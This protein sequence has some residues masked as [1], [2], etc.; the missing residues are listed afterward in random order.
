MR[1]WALAQPT[2]FNC[3]FWE[4]WI[5]FRVCTKPNSRDIDLLNI[6]KPVVIGKKETVASFDVD[7][8]NTFTPLC[9]TELPTPGG[10]DIVDELNAQAQKAC[11]RLGSKDAHSRYAKWIATPRRPAF[12]PLEGEHY[13]TAFP[14]HAIPGTKGFELIAGLPD[15]TDYDFFVWKGIELSMHPYGVCYHDLC[16]KMSTG[17]I[18]FLRARKIETVLVGGLTTEYCVLRTVLQLC[19]AG[20]KVIVN[21]AACRGYTS[22]DVEKALAQM[23]ASGAI[24]IENNVAIQL[25]ED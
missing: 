1:G 5:L 11:L 6:M 25:A 16:E 24:I 7:A 4:E 12:S 10:T 19:K 20:F 8:Q 17:V 3:F 18:E 15:I 9:P 22:K 2:F 23:K 14:A 21:K 13:N